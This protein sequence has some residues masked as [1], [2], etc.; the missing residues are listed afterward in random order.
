MIETIEEIDAAIHAADNWITGT[1]TTAW[2][3]YEGSPIQGCNNILE[4][5]RRDSDV[6]P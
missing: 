1:T 6:L 5:V 2:A 3:T 4:H